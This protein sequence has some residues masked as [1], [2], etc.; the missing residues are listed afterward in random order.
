LGI[1]TLLT[2]KKYSIY[3]KSTVIVSDEIKDHIKVHFW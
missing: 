1:D 2:N 3:N